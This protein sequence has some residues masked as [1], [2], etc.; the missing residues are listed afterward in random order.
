MLKT[1][2]RPCSIQALSFIHLCNQYRPPP[3]A[4][5][6]APDHPTT[7]SPGQSS[8]LASQLMM[9][10]KGRLSIDAAFDSLPPSS[11][12]IHIQAN[13]IIIVQKSI[14]DDQT[15]SNQAKPSQATPA[16]KTHMAHFHS[17]DPPSVRP[18]TH[19]PLTFSQVKM[20]KGKKRS[21]RAG[22]KVESPNC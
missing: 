14:S 8:H 21:G 1:V 18:P 3:S 22:C 7:N 10:M 6:C 19:H 9:K 15:K 11:V 2:V 17:I 16:E 13:I 20:E 12:I 5:Q 4:I